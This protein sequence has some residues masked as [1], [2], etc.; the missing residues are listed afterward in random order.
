MKKEFNSIQDGIKSALKDLSE[1][2][3]LDATKNY[4]GVAKNKAYFYKCAEG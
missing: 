1:D 2:E 4:A 3:I